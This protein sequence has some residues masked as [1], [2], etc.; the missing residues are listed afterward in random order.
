MPAGSGNLKQ[1]GDRSDSREI[2]AHDSSA[3]GGREGAWLA[4][5]YAGESSGTR[6]NGVGRLP[7]RRRSLPGTFAARDFGG[8][9]A[10]SWGTAVSAF[11]Q[12]R[13]RM[14]L[15]AGANNGDS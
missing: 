6:W 8:L 9:P 10:E 1:G 4:G 15:P 3:D 13:R 7:A 11:L 12:Q 2:D 14:R 5:E